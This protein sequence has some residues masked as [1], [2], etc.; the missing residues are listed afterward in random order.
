MGDDMVLISGVEEDDLKEPYSEA[1][2]DMWSLF[3]SIQR[4][5]PSLV[6]GNR[7]IWVRCSGIPIHLWSQDCFAKVTS[8][9]GTLIL[10]DDDTSSFSRLDYARLL[11]KTSSILPIQHISEIKINGVIIQVRVIEDVTT[12]NGQC[13]C[14]LWK[15]EGVA[16][17]S[18]ASELAVN[19]C[20]SSSE[21]S[22]NNTWPE[23]EGAAMADNNQSWKEDEI[24]N[25]YPKV[26]DQQL[27]HERVDG[28]V[29]TH[30]DRSKGTESRIL[31]KV[32]GEEDIKM[33]LEEAVQEELHEIGNLMG[34]ME[35][36]S[37]RAKNTNVDTNLYGTR[38]INSNTTNCTKVVN[39]V[40][41]IN[42]QH[43]I[44]PNSIGPM[45]LIE[46]GYDPRSNLDDKEIR[47]NHGPRPISK[48]A[49]VTN[50]FNMEQLR[51]CRVLDVD[52]KG[53]HS[54]STIETGESVSRM[55]CS[56]DTG[57]VVR[58][59]INNSGKG[60][61]VSTKATDEQ[62]TR[63]ATVKEVGAAMVP[64]TIASPVLSFAA[65]R[66]KQVRLALHSFS[67]SLSDCDI[68]NCHRLVT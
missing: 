12:N 1:I 56:L 45:L 32:G 11:I 65:A 13:K 37:Y 15:N 38:I 44:G 26:L 30:I 42:S 61:R 67:N 53:N 36:T 6:A 34:G 41:H 27:T 59:E 50:Q 52:S 58:S 24:S 49:K 29:Y 19:L 25:C 5:T 9:F 4:W 60:K 31:V 18:A 39:S 8:V 43:L 40:S 33:G 17:S 22:E 14:G 64:T 68:R 3:H 10:M 57:L 48:Q 46:R 62:D 16:L 7:L 55:G 66:R 21:C 23:G 20:S 51:V 54:G 47:E 2:R 28:P 63:E 35:V